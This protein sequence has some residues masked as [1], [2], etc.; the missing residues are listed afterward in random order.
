MALPPRCCGAA[1]HRDSDRHNDQPTTKRVEDTVK[2]L[3]RMLV[4]LVPA[5]GLVLALST[6]ASAHKSVDYIDNVWFYDYGAVT[7][8]SAHTNISVCDH[9]ADGTGVWVEFYYHV[10]GRHDDSYQT[11][12]DGNG[13]QAGCGSWSLPANGYFLGYQGR[14]GSTGTDYSGWNWGDF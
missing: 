11:I 2:N 5:V 1:G 7:I 6:P 12:S 4:A 9:Y 3:K 13:A 14:Y 10:T 8:N